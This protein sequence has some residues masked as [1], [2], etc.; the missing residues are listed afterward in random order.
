[1]YQ[2]YEMKFLKTTILYRLQSTGLIKTSFNYLIKGFDDGDIKLIDELFNRMNPKLKVQG[3][4]VYMSSRNLELLDVRGQP[5][6]FQPLKMWSIQIAI[7]GYKTSPGGIVTPI[8]KI[9]DAQM[10]E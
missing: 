1:M 2:G 5:T 7:Q 6:V 10:V 3:N 9:N 8:W 4:D